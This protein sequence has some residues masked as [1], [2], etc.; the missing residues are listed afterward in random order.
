MNRRLLAFWLVFALAGPSAA[1]EAKKDPARLLP[2]PEVEADPAIPTLKDVVGHRWGQEI[3]SHAEI[4]RYI[5]ALA[6]AAPER[7]K[8]VKYGAV[9][10]A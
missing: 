4:E 8:L 7:C 10:S 2:V 1:Q 3:S 9:Q 6:K 5:H